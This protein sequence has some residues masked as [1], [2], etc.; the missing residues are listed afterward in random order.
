MT[1]RRGP[2]LIEL[3]DSAPAPEPAAAPPVSDA[4]RPEGQAMQVVATLGRRQRGSR[5]WR[6]LLGTLAAVIGFVLS[7]AAW[8]F[9]TGLLAASPLLGGIATALIGLFVALLIAVALRE[10]AA[11]SRLARLDAL[12][13]ELMDTG[14]VQMVL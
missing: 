14:L 10:L 3:E 7:L 4:P 6:W 8:E 13:R 12:H 2:V 1:E 9:V 11:F 5:L